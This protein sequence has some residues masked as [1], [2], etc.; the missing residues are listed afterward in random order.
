[1]PRSTMVTPEQPVHMGHGIGMVGDDQKA[2]IGLLPHLVYQFAEA[3]Y[4]GVVQWGIDLVEY[5]NGRGVGE[6]HRKDQCQRGER[7]FAA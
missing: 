3:L 2:S 4:I 6:K 7:L 1:M 5:A